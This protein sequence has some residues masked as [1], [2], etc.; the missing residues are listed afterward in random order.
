MGGIEIGE[1]AMIGAG[2]VITKDIPAFSLWYGNPARHKGYVTREG[3]ILNMELKDK[4]GNQF[5][6]KN[7]EPK[8]I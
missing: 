1:Y 2:S 4:K 8:M 6:R 3:V 5:I 7:G